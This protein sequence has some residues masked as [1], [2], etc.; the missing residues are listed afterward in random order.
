MPRRQE[1]CMG[2]EGAAIATD[3][4]VRLALGRKAACEEEWGAGAVTGDT[5]GG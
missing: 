1:R 2:A 4:Q 3:P 5:A